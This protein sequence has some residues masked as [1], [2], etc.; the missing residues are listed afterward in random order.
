[1]RSGSRARRFPNGAA[2]FASR[3]NRVVTPNL[4]NI[5]GH[6][7]HGYSIA[8]ADE[9][10]RGAMGLAANGPIRGVPAY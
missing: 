5:S 9:F 10:S 8:L 4:W 6:I 7:A 3:C 2:Y 1:M